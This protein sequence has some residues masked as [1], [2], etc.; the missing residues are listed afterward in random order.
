MFSTPWPCKRT[1]YLSFHLWQM[2]FLHCHL[3][4]LDSGKKAWQGLCLFSCSVCIISRCSTE[5]PPLAASLLELFIPSCFCNIS[6]F[7]LPLSFLPYNVP[8]NWNSSLSTQQVHSFPSFL[9]TLIFSLDSKMSF[10]SHSRFAYVTSILKIVQ[11]HFMSSCHN[12]SLHF[13]CKDI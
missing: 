13:H 7:H 2:Q 5:I 1:A 10:H 3:G 12:S 8:I 9:Q 4:H 11:H 6:Y